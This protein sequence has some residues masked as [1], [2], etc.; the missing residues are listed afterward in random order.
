[1]P[2][3]L[4]ESEWGNLNFTIEAASDFIPSAGKVFPDPGV[5]DAVTALVAQAKGQW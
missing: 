5:V 3:D 2:F 4:Q 1:M